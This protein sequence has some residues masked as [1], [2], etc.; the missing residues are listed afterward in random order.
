MADLGGFTRPSDEAAVLVASQARAEVNLG[1]QIQP[2][3]APVLADRHTLTTRHNGGV[4]AAL[5]GPW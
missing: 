5:N 2:V 3:Q 4:V 1:T